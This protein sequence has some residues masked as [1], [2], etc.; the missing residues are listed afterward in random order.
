MTN[1]KI[2]DIIYLLKVKKLIFALKTEY[3]KNLQPCAYRNA[4]RHGHLSKQPGMERIRCYTGFAAVGNAVAGG[5][6]PTKK[7]MALILV[8]VKII[9][10]LPSPQ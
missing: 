2:F 7:R 5:Q 3:I 8:A 6:R 9:D 1:L 10:K 4:M